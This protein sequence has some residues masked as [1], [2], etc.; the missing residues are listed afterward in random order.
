MNAAARKGSTQDLTL[1]VV[2]D[3]PQVVRLIRRF[4]EN[5]G[6]GVSSYDGGQKALDRLARDRVDVAVVD[7]QMPQVGGLEVLRAIRQADP[8]CQTI[9]MSGAATIDS[10]IEAAKLGAIDY[11]TKPFDFDRLKALLATVKD[12]AARRR[13]LLVAEREVAK[14]L[15][16]CGMIGRSSVMQELFGL[17]RRLAPHV[18][19]VL[20]LGETGVGKELVARALYESGPRRHKRF[21]PINCSAIAESLVESELFGHMRGAFTG[22]TDTKPGMFEVADGGTLFLDEV[23]EL[24][25]AMQAKLLRA[26]ESGE[27][28]RVGAVEPRHVDVHVIAATNQSL[29]AKVDAGRFRA[30]LYYRLNVVEIAIPP[31]RERREDIPYLTA[32]FVREASRRLGK[33]LIGPT[34]AA[35][36]WLADARWEGNIRELRNVI[37]RACI[38][39]DGEFITE[40]ELTGSIARPVSRDAPSPHAPSVPGADDASLS[41]LERER[42]QEVL[43]QTGGNKLSAAR[44]LGLSRRALYRRLERYGLDATPKPR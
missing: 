26:L 24:P 12:E 31:L 18:R 35:E 10:A 11:L 44:I 1:L 28:Q 5:A 30:D 33:R 37:E 41:T 42:I 20:V 25:L 40:R 43:E 38:L 23:G 9:L 15:E 7:L 4:G 17:I 13:R 6:F 16:F 22:A 2:D 21:V 29:R 14:E 27:V 32:A 8:D 3:D 39:A 19:T 34:P 36:R